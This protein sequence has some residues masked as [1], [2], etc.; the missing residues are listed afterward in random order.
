MV[1]VANSA[2]ATTPPTAP[3]TIAPT[4]VGLLVLDGPGAEELVAVPDTEPRLVLVWD[5]IAKDSIVDRLAS[6]KPPAGTVLV[7]PPS[8]LYV[9]GRLELRW[10]RGRR[11][12]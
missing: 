10:N 9:E 6:L 5:V 4:G 11:L 12:R 2:M 8:L 3:P 1:P 7:E